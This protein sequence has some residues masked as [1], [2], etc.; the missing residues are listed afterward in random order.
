[1]DVGLIG[2]FLGG[3]LALLSPC[4]ALLLPGFFAARVTS[5]LGL[6]PH[7]LVFYT[8]L[9]VT[10][11]PLGLGVGAIGSLLAGNH[12]LLVGS[13]SVLLV[14]L[15]VVHALGG[16][17]EIG[18]L[19]PGF[20]RLQRAS[21]RGAGY[22]RT[23]LLGAVGGVAGFCAGPILGA[24]LTLALGRGSVAAA[25]FLLAVYSAGMVAP[26]M[27]LAAAW[28]AWGPTHLPAW[29]RGRTMSIVVG[30]L[31]I[32]LG[33]LFWMTNGLVSAPSLVPTA[34]LSRWQEDASALDSLPVQVGAIV[35]LGALALGLW[36][37]WDR[38]AQQDRG[39]E[40][41]A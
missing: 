18:R 4:G 1:M 17:F 26:L 40:H 24:V 13:T 8:G 36:W 21:G 41:R 10:L 15:G 32:A 35:L 6:I 37:R 25:G 31:I 20:T 2:A 34:V 30:A 22:A 3:V 29:V 16:G 28:R 11:V 33:V 7:A 38:R 27:L 19:L 23:F 12:L 39:T 9:V 14:V 5:M